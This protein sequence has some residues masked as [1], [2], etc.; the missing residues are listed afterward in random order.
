VFG[1]FVAGA[2]K[3]GRNVSE[4]EFGLGLRLLQERR[5]VDFRPQRLVRVLVLV[6]DQSEACLV[7]VLDLE[8]AVDH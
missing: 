3:D 6:F 8:Q 2:A 1:T 5:H 7:Y 4:V